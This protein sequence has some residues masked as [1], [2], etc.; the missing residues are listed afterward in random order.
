[1]TPQQRREVFF[2]F[3][4]QNNALENWKGN[5]FSLWDQTIS[6]QLV[7]EVRAHQGNDG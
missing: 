5:V 7:G 1:M 2:K 4:A 3:L 6:Y